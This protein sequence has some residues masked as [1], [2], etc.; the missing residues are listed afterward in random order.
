MDNKVIGKRLRLLR[1]EHGLSAKEAA[2][3]ANYSY[4]TMISWEEGKYRP[5]LDALVIMADLYNVTLDYL[6]GRSEKCR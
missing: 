6:V 2:K 1:R 4:R 3:K 5:S